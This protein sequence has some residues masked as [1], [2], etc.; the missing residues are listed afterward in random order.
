MSQSKEI[1]EKI[2]HTNL[3]KYGCEY[4]VQANEVK[5]KIKHAN[6]KNHPNIIKYL[7]S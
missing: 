6:D 2:K 4:G 1:K 3:E 7:T 5:E